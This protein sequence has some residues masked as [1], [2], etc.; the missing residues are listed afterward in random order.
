MPEIGEVSSDGSW[1]VPLKNVWGLWCAFESV[2]GPV[3]L[4]TSMQPAISMYATSREA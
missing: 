3:E 1:R 2:D 4:L